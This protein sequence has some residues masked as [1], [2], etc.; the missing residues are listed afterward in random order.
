MNHHEK[1][2]K[3]DFPRPPDFAALFRAGKQAD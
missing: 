1:D 2:E 3:R